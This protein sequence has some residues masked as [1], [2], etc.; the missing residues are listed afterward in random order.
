MYSKI[1]PMEWL[2]LVKQYDRNHLT[3]RSF[4]LVKLMSG[5]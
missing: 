3:T 2:G 4:F 5:G 1:N